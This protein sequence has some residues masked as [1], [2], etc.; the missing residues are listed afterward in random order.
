[1]PSRMPRSGEIDDDTRELA[2]RIL[3]RAGAMMEDASVLALL[4]FSRQGSIRK[5]LAN[6][7][8]PVP[9]SASLSVLPGC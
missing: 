4:P 3:T 9:Q 5:S 1:M 2:A 7:N 6:S 8:G